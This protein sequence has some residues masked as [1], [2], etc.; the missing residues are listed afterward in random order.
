MVVSLCRRFSCNDDDVISGGKLFLMEAD[1]LPDPPLDA[2]ADDA[3]AYLFT[4]GY[5]QPA[6]LQIIF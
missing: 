1:S 6:L 3:V 5:A 4:D 2:V